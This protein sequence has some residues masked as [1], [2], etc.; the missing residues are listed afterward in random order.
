LASF[1]L[2]HP[3]IIRPRCPVGSSMCSQRPPTGCSFRP[4]VAQADNV[5]H[6]ATTTERRDLGPR[7]RNLGRD[8]RFTGNTAFANNVR[9]RRAEEAITLA[10]GCD[11]LPHIIRVGVSMGVC[12]C[13]TTVREPVLKVASGRDP[14]ALLLRKKK[15]LSMNGVMLPLR[16]V[17]T[18]DKLN[19]H[20][21][22]RMWP[23]WDRALA[24][25]KVD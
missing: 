13:P 6:A 20:L 14:V 9:S 12:V 17:G 3:R 5:V 23:P 16:D 10:G 21:F 24:L 25:W 18:G 7:V 1:G 15:C 4:D 2:E 22:L 8:S 11:T 19:N